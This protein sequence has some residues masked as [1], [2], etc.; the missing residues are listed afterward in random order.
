MMAGQGGLEKLS[1]GVLSAE[2]QEKLRLFKIKT[3][4]ENEKYL[5]SHSEVEV[6]IGDFVRD[7]LLKR[8]ADICEF[9]AEHFTNPNLHMVTASKMEGKSE[10]K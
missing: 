5:R 1:V 8:P 6:L 3:R 4:I 10:M 2:Q 9:A 7:V